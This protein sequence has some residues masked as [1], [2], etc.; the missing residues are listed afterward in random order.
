MNRIIKKF[1]WLP[2]IIVNISN[3]QISWLENVEIEQK[4][5]NNKWFN[6]RFKTKCKN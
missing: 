5:I 4:F 3:I 1:S 6:M 2:I